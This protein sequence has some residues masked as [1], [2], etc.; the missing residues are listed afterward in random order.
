MAEQSWEIVGNTIRETP[1]NIAR[2]LHGRLAPSRD[3]MREMLLDAGFGLGREIEYNPDLSGWWNGFAAEYWPNLAQSALS[4][5][6]E[7]AEEEAIDRVGFIRTLELDISGGFGGRPA[8]AAV[9]LLGAVHESETGA[10][11]WQFRGFASSESDKGFNLGALYRTDYRTEGGES[12]AMIGANV[13]LDFLSNSETGDF[14]RYSGGLEFRSA[15]VDAY[16]NQYFPITSPFAAPGSGETAYTAGGRDFALRLHSPRVKWLAGALTHYQWSGEGGD[17]DES[18]LKYALE[19]R[20]P[21]DGGNNLLFE[22]EYDQPQEG[23]GQFGWRINYYHTIGKEDS[24][25]L[26]SP[27]FRPRDY[28]YEA[29]RR[30]YSQRVRT[31]DGGRGGRAEIRVEDIAAARVELKAHTETVTIF[32]AGADGEI[33]FSQNG[34]TRREAPGFSFRYLFPGNGLATLRL[35]GLGANP[36]ATLVFGNS[37]FVGMRGGDGRAAGR[38]RTAPGAAKRRHSFSPPSRAV[39][40]GVVRAVCRRRGHGGAGGVRC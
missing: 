21:L 13:F 3:E 15:W 17:E 9:N 35:F 34:E 25:Q 22:L 16:V 37:D 10:A 18:G 36:R 38:G 32:R 12:A 8:E 5:V 27:E 28:F 4:E 23:G 14:W 19:F 29:A 2:G 7:L 31:A 20:P 26:L 33:L 39:L 24:H 40:S 30:D 6:A 1:E 11:L